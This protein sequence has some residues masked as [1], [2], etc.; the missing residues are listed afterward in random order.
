MQVRCVCSTLSVLFACL[1][2]AEIWPVILGQF[3]G[4]PL[5]FPLLTH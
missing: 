4:L 3:G 2:G 1:L 5:L